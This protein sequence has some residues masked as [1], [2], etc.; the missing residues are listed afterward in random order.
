VPEE[1]R[2]NHKQGAAARQGTIDD[3]V[4]GSTPGGVSFVMEKPDSQRLL[5]HYS[6]FAIEGAIVVYGENNVTLPGVEDRELVTFDFV[7]QSLGL[8]RHLDRGLSPFDGDGDRPA[9]Y[10]M[11]DAV[12]I[13][14]TTAAAYES[15]REQTDDQAKNGVARYL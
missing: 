12:E 5:G 9:S 8:I 1:E 2:S 4:R 13:A 10:A 7:I 11:V 14:A 3:E 15:E 6:E